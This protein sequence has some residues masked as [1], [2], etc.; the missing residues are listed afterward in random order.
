MR[1]AVVVA[2]VFIVGGFSL[3]GFSMAFSTVAAGPSLAVGP[4]YVEPINPSDPNCPP[5]GCGS[6]LYHAVGATS[7]Q[8]AMVVIELGSLS[9]NWST[10]VVT[11]VFGLTLTINWGDGS[12]N[13][14]PSYWL[15]CNNV[16]TV[17]SAYE[18]PGDGIGEGW[19]Y[20]PAY[21]A[22]YHTYQA[23]GTYQVTAT[24]ANGVAIQGASFGSGPAVVATITTMTSY[25]VS[26]ITQPTTV[27]YTTTTNGQTLTETSVSTVTSISTSTSTFSTQTTV[28]QTKTTTYPPTTQTA[29]ITITSPTTTTETTTHV[30]PPP[31]G[32]SFDPTVLW[33]GVGLLAV[34]I[35]T[36]GAGLTRV[37]KR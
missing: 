30:A 4:V 34:G 12:T 25:V 15:N 2:L 11:D 32:P 21:V 26:T 9:W 16:V 3:V 19:A 28:T 31:A 10:T 35:V 33:S 1:V 36:L 37:K 17:C 5:G 22:F 18:P 23:Q 20:G 14:I 6:G 27:T 13:N 29:T 24:A 7:S 8:T